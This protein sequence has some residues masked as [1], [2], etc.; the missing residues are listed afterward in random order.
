MSN[1]LTRTRPWCAVLTTALLAAVAAPAMALDFGTLRLYLPPGQTPYAEITL[2][3]SVGLDPA[4]IRARIATPDAYGVAGMR[5]SPALQNV[6]ITPQGGPNGQIVL[7]LER[8]PAPGE[9]ADLDLLLLVGD[10]M[11]LALGEYRVDLRGSGRE[12]AAAPAGSRLATGSMNSTPGQDS[13]ATTAPVTSN[14]STAVATAPMERPPAVSP[15]PVNTAAASS[16]DTSLADVQAALNAWAQAWSSRDVDGYLAAYT[17][18]YAGRGKGAGH[19]AWVQQRRSRILS[20][21]SISV[22]ITKPQFTVRG[23]AVVA[24]FDQRYRG[25]DLV[26]RSKKR[27][28]LVRIDNRWL[29]QD[30]G[31]LQ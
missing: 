10:R 11:S 6:V 5:Y 27:V 22:E 8:L 25:D 3:D 29:I 13:G 24:T 20:K 2:S 23:D 4:D 7:R 14:P 26:E 19:D 1:F 16:S 12:F 9:A 15:R 17:A 31:E 21:K 28:V 18:D 30:E